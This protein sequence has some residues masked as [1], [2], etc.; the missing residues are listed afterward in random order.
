[1][2]TNNVRGRNPR[3][4][5]EGG[6]YPSL[7][8][9]GLSG[10]PVSRILRWTTVVFVISLSLDG[11]DWS[12]IFGRGDNL[13]SILGIILVVVFLA[14]RRFHIRIL[15]AGW[16][17][18]FVF[19]GAMI[20]TEFYRFGVFSVVDSTRSMRALFTTIQ[21]AAMFF[22][23]RDVVGD[24][25]VRNSVVKAY[26]VSSCL[27]S[28]VAIFDWIRGG[29]VGAAAR[30]SVMDRNEN[31]F[32]FAS[33][34]A[35]IFLM[36]WFL[37]SDR[38]SME[39][40]IWVF[41]PV[42]M[43]FLSVVNSG[44]RGGA[45]ALAVGVGSVLVLTYRPGRFPAYVTFLT[46]VLGLVLLAVVLNPVLQQR[47]TGAISGTDR[48]FRPQLIEASF[49]LAKEHP[50]A[51]IGPAYDWALGGEVGF[52]RISAHNTYLQ[53][54]LSYG[55]LGL[56]PFVLFLISVF[57]SV[58]R[59]RRSP[60]GALAFASYVSLLMFYMSGHEMN[61][62]LG[63]TLMALVV[64]VRPQAGARL[65][66]SHWRADGPQGRWRHASLERPNL[67]GQDGVAPSGSP[68][69]SGSKSNR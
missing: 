68:G 50:I 61:Y 35:I 69:I 58:W 55:I 46:P 48:G 52:E 8:G 27:F 41:V 64:S 37:N 62:K 11:L 6:L 17:W 51:G 10:A 42:G 54:L 38:R 29:R 15:G 5:A 49:D 26:V 43:L 47:F 21:V 13:S 60:E 14:T 28:V 63:W 9:P 22:I 31:E 23:I 12:G 40:R 36:W 57:L 56:V 45:L 53:V 39:R 19:L 59:T 30:I 18:F 1:L 7:G 3:K 65:W 4:Y 44:S 66:A 20:V 34:L 25:Q 2:R 33:G 16:R 32:S 24:R 67:Q